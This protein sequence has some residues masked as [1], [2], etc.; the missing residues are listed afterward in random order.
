M[1][2]YFILFERTYSY[3]VKVAWK[4]EYNMEFLRAIYT[5]LLLPLPFFFI[6][7]AVM[8][9]MKTYNIDFIDIE[10]FVFSIFL[11]LIVINCLLFVRKK[12]YLDLV[13]QVKKFD[14]KTRRKWGTIT[15]L[16]WLVPT[17]ILFF[18]LGLP[19]QQNNPVLVFIIHEKSFIETLILEKLLILIEKWING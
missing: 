4:K 7:L 18:V 10:Y 14:E 19:H 12:R 17:F 16:F 13:I 5:C 9:A 3:L 8:L 2:F 6:V 1:N 15:L 11:I